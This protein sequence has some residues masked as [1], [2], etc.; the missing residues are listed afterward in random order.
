MSTREYRDLLEN[1]TRSKKVVSSSS[2][3]K[4]NV[5]LIDISKFIEIA[6]K[7]EVQT[8]AARIETVCRD[9]SMLSAILE[10]NKQI[11]SQYAEYIDVFSQEKT[12][13]L[14]KHKS[15]DDAIDTDDRD[16]FF[17][18]IYNLST[19]KLEVLRKYIDENL[20][21][22]LITLF[23]SSVEDLDWV[24]KRMGERQRTKMSQ[25]GR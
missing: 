20:K 22:S 13:T 9:S 24:E 7:N 14:S 1:K 3:N 8:F 4:L 25:R 5:A 16:S 18:S 21:K 15:H 23:I 17:D 19:H 10:N 6:L 11:S 2:S 12:N